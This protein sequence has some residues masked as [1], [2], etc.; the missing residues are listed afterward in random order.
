MAHARDDTIRLKLLKIG[1]VIIKNTRLAR[2]LIPESYPSWKLFR[3]VASRL[4]SGQTKSDLKNVTRR[5]VRP[6][7]DILG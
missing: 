5:A 6:K 3:L 7:F 1:A 2:L 4:C